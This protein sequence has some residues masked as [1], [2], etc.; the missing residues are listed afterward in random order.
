M[1]APPTTHSHPHPTTR[2][3][4][5]STRLT[6]YSR[7]E[8]GGESASPH[9]ELGMTH[10]Y[11]LPAS[12]PTAR[13]RSTSPPHNFAL[14]PFALSHSF[15]TRV[16]TLH[17]TSRHSLSLPAPVALRSPRRG[18]QTSSQLTDKQTSDPRPTKK[19]RPNNHTRYAITRHA[20][21]RT[22]PLPC[23]VC[24]VEQPLTCLRFLTTEKH[25]AKMDNVTMKMTEL[26]VDARTEPQQRPPTAPRPPPLVSEFSLIFS[27]A[28]TP[29]EFSVIFS[30]TPPCFSCYNTN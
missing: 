26:D 13:R 23:V 27:H 9:T 12:F 16:R 19:S 22:H 17:T 20:S 10:A 24:V 1:R 28:R 11:L 21:T 14:S 2:R 6:Q 25:E 8:G 29:R 15:D 4:R 18:T 3:R 7:A 30:L 5:T